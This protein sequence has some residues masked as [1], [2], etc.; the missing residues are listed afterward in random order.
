MESLSQNRIRLVTGGNYLFLPVKKLSLD[1]ETIPR[2]RAD[3][4]KNRTSAYEKFE[5]ITQ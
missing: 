1:D 5:V 2:F 3:I 4:Q